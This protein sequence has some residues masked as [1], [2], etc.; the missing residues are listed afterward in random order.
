MSTTKKKFWQGSKQATCDHC[1]NRL[2]HVF[3]DAKLPLGPWGIVCDNCFKYL[4]C[5]LG[6]G[7]GQK[8]STTTLEK[9]D[10]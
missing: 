10:G 4:N 7:R 6:L 3:Y 5:S 1:K 9:L 2:T 8:Y